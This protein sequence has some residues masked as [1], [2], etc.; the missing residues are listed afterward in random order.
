VKAALVCRCFGKGKHE[1]FWLGHAPKC[2]GRRETSAKRVKLSALT[3]AE[4]VQRFT[5]LAAQHGDAIYHCETARANRIYP[6]IQAVADELKFRQ[7]DQRAELLRLY[8][9]PDIF[10][11]LNAA[12]AHLQS[13]RSSPVQQYRKSPT[14]RHSLRRATPAWLFACW[15]GA[16]IGRN[17]ECCF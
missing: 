2:P 5:E 4:L 16:S 10:V 9:H 13:R 1:L 7:G 14:P 17:E 3:T 11:R 15:T 8:D 6:K 12:H